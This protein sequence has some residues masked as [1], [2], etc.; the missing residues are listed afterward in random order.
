MLLSVV[1]TRLKR[2][3]QCF[4]FRAFIFVRAVTKHRISSD[5]LPVESSRYNNIPFDERTCRLCKLKRS[6][7]KQA[8][9][10]TCSMSMFIKR[11]GIALSRR[12]TKLNSSFTLF[13]NQNLFL[14]IISIKVKSMTKLAAKLL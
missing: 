7:M 9:F 6:C 12:Y 3:S 14:N 5:R 2:A 8:S 10:N 4:H 1:K 13:Y 11:L